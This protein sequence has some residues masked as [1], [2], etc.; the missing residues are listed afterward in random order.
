M[1]LHQELTSNEL[2]RIA[3]IVHLLQAFAAS[4]LDPTLLSLQLWPSLFKIGFIEFSSHFTP[5]LNALDF[6]Q[7]ALILKVL[8][9]GFV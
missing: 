5:N 3:N 1:H 9:I 7:V 2:I 6:S 4:L 8:P